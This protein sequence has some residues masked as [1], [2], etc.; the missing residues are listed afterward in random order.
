MD[1]DDVSVL[2]RMGHSNV[3]GCE[4]RRGSIACVV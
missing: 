1:S 4:A 3:D 2:T